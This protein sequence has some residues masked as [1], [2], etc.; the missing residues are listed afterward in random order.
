MP[1]LNA[2]DLVKSYG[3]DLV[4]DGID[5]K[6]EKG[7]K[8]AV[9][10][11]NGCGKTT[12][13]KI[14]AGLEEPDR[15]SVRLERG[16]RAGYLAQEY[17]AA[18]RNRTIWEEMEAVFADVQ[19]VRRQ[20]E[21][22]ASA[23][24]ERG[25]GAAT[26]LIDRY[27]R[28]QARLE[29]MDGYNLDSRIERVLRGLGFTPDDW[30][31]PIAVLSGGES[32]RT[33]L[34]GLLLRQPDLLLLDEPTNHLDLWAVAWLEEYLVSYRG[35][36]VVVS[37]DRYFLDRV[38]GGVYELAAG[39]ISFY[40]GG[41]TNYR[42][43]RAER[44]HEYERARAIREREIARKERLVRESAADERSKRQARSIAKSIARMQRL[45]GPPREEPSLRLEFSAPSRTGRFVLTVEGLSKSYGGRPLLTGAGFTM[46]AGEKVGVIG[47]N[48]AGKTTLLRMLVGLEKPDAGRIER[49][50]NVEIGYFAQAEIPRGEGTV[51]STMQEAGAGDNLATRR[52]LARFLFRGDDVW[53]KVAD[54]SGGEA[55]RLALARLT[56]GRANL[57]ILDEP[58]NHLDLPS[59]EALED[60][61]AAYTGS[62]LVVS[63][64]RYFLARVSHRILALLDGRLLPF[65]DYESYAAWHA[66]EEARAAAERSQA[67]ASRREEQRR[68]RIKR[69]APQKEARRR[70]LAIEDV[71][72]RLA[73]KE[74]ERAELLRE[75]ARPESAGD[76]LRLQD[77]STNLAH[78]E[79]EIQDLYQQ[80]EELLDAT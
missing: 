78:L 13:L 21:E 46:E 16:L 63:H 9:V 47:P 41:Y 30:R 40:P 25:N 70:A 43:L 38:V 36:V 60:A 26:G 42:A 17:T 5:F 44:E 4:L 59:I 66:E 35:A 6:V 51:F 57:L 24:A 55:R 48:G 14:L 69:Q 8:L 1:I 62:L 79:Q 37:H 52:H 64:D 19:A 3:A 53:K 74:E 29:E 50:H 71:E 23:M 20:L 22:T 32:T 77:L 67:I 61:L 80:W 12:L 39:K 27:A 34:A 18:A 72:R 68:E 65:P 15:G 45:D 49:G 75:L 28:L 33:A 31:K 73:A 56:L 58:T 7:Q 2:V 11:R 10:G 76:Y 54:L